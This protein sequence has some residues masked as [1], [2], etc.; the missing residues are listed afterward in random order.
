MEGDEKRINNNLLL[1]EIE[2]IKGNRAPEQK[3]YYIQ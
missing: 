2:R 3:D 1:M